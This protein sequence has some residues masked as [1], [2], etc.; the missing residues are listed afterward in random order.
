MKMLI[1]EERNDDFIDLLEGSSEDRANAYSMLLEDIKR[2]SEEV[3][4]AKKF[5]VYK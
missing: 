1:E 5:N 3:K 4:D 2:L